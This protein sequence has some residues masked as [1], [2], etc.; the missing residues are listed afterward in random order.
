ME[1][2]TDGGGGLQVHIGDALAPLTTIP[3]GYAGIVVDLFCDGRVL[4]QLQEVSTWSELR[5][6]LMPNGRIMVNCGG[7]TDE[8]SVPIAETRPECSPTDQTWQQN[9]TLRTLY[10][11]FPE[12]LSWK[13]LG[14]REG[15]NFLALTGHPP[16]LS[17]WSAAVP[18]PLSNSVTKWSICSPALSSA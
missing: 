12:Q 2:R 8:S 10:K 3:G 18:Q 1:K 11:A 6:K 13:K 5:D 15:E 7:V 4:P 9:S 16:D 14:K 17:V